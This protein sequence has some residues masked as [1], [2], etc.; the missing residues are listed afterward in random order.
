MVANL[1]TERLL[2]REFRAGD[3]DAYATRIFGDVAVMRYLPKR[4]APAAERAQKTMDFFNEHWRYFPYGP[5]A[6]VEKKSGELIGHCGLRF[7]PEIEETEVL[8]AFGK[9]F[10]GKGYATEAARSSVQYGFHNIG[11]D[12]IIALAVPE[13]IASRRVMEHCGLKHEKDA[14]LFGMDVVYYAMN[15]GEYAASA[16]NTDTRV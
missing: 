11:L 6:V 9:E 14:H 7:I 2:L 8:Y 10:W 5:W 13:N 4:D 15:R 16:N 12:R 3:L 1:E